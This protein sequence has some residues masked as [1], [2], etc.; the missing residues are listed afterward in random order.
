MT[1]EAVHNVI[2]RRLGMIKASDPEL[3][4]RWEVMH[5]DWGIIEV[6]KDSEVIGFE[7]VESHQSWDRHERL[8]LYSTTVAAG[9]YVIVAVPEESYIMMMTTIAMMPPPRPL[10]FCYDR[11]GNIRNPGCS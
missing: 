7:F 1:S 10:L 2:R 11:K 4:V 6:S 3:E 9:H 5:D 8:T